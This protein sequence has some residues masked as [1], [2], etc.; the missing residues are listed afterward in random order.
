MAPLLLLLLLQ[1]YQD[2]PCIDEDSIKCTG[3]WW[4]GEEGMPATPSPC[5]PA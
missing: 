1:I 5:R 4:V 2:K 3:K